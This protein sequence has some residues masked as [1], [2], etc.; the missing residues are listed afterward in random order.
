MIR[1]NTYNL[2][3]NNKVRIVEVVRASV[4]VSAICGLDIKSGEFRG[5]R[6]YFLHFIF[7]FPLPTSY[8]RTSLSI[9]ELNKY[10]SS[11]ENTTITL[12]LFEEPV[13]I[14]FYTYEMSISWQM[15]S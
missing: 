6:D 4:V 1:Y 11:L 7:N 9:A 14:G 12:P 8:C 2:A 13:K 10:R 15:I 3:T 5:K